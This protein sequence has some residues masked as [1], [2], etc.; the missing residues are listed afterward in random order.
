MS[1][2]IEFCRAN[3]NT[4]SEQV[5]DQL[6]KNPGDLEDA[7]VI[8]YGC[9][10]NCGQCYLE[11]FAMVEGMIVAGETPEEL[12]NNIRNFVKKKQEEDKQWRELGF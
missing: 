1:I 5:K 4:G 10:G 8:E 6:L 2:M 7:E 3:L 9:L 11:P 12:L